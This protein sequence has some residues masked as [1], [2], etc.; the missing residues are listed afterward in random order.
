MDRRLKKKNSFS[1]ILKKL[2]TINEETINPTQKEDSELTEKD[3]ISKKINNEI[4]KDENQLFVFEDIDSH[5]DK[6]IIDI[7]QN[8][9]NLKK[10]RKYKYFEIVKMFIES[11]YE[12]SENDFININDIKSDFNDYISKLDESIKPKDFNMALNVEDITLLDNRFIYKRVNICKYCKSR[13]RIGCCEKYELN[14][15]YPIKQKM[16]I[17]NITHK[18]S[19]DLFIKVEDEIS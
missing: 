7:V 3:K 16:F 8:E 2:N 13:L 9:I 12:Y 18:Q 1:D 11:K 6:N 15:L 17:I 19:I 4:S 10:N 14:R 5:K